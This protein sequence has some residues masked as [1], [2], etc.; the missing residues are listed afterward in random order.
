LEEEVVASDVEE[1]EPG[2]RV[3]GH[4][5]SVAEDEEVVAGPVAGPEGR[6]A[7]LREAAGWDM[8]PGS[9][10]ALGRLLRR[11]GR[12]AQCLVEL[13]AELR[14]RGLLYPGLEEEIA[15]ELRA[16][17]ARLYA[18]GLRAL[19][20]AGS[21]DRIPDAELRRLCVYAE[22]G[23]PRYVWDALTRGTAGARRPDIVASYMCRYMPRCCR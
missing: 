9:L 15:R 17:R 22:A 11:W 13:R 8:L 14:R 18:L 12:Y 21:C 3:L 4:V 23:P 19:A 20:L 5:E 6:D 10:E 16:E 7:L 2:E 1:V